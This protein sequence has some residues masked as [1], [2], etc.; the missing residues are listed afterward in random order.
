MNPEVAVYEAL[1]K[2]GL[3]RCMADESTIDLRNWLQVELT[4]LGGGA[5]ETAMMTWPESFTFSE[6]MLDEFERVAALPANERRVLDWPWQ[7]WRERID[8]MEPGML[9]V[10]SAPDGHGK[11]IYSESIAEHWAKHRNRVVFLHFELNRK[12]MMM[13]RIARHTST[14]VLDQKSGHLTQAQRAKIR[15]MAPI[16]LAWD[17][18]ITYLHTPGWS[19]E[20]TVEELRKLRTEGACDCVVFDY[21]EKCAA[22]KRQLQ[23]FGTNTWQREADNVE[24]LKNWAEAAEVPVLMVTQMS[25]AGKSTTFD[26]MDRTDIRGAGE[27]TEKANLVVLLKRE[28]ID[29]TLSTDV[30]VMIDKQ[31]MGTLGT[32]KQRMQGEYFR[33]G[34]CA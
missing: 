33:V 26:R 22:S 5:D 10:I 6:A 28:R 23:F 19:M 12:L 27:K 21:L 16:M 1:F 17:G 32:F 4:R 20:R 31:N 9:A 18:Y 3:R 24:Q 11:S 8:C 29:G 13:R 34:D 7:S 14:L 30:D 2:E 15:E 25:K